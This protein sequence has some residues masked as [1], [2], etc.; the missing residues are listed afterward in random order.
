MAQQTTPAVNPCGSS[1]RGGGGGEAQGG[2]TQ[3][4]GGMVFPIL[5]FVLIFYFMIIRPQNKRKKEQDTM[6]N[7]ISRGD[8]IIT[9][10]GIF[11]TVREIRED[12]FMLEIAEGIK[13]RILK[14]SISTKRAPG[15]AVEE[16]KD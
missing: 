3:G 11:G 8:Q 12:S 6:I 10:S 1:S 14:T 9:Y 4:F 5:I 15:P 13:I 2:G 16:K 7:A